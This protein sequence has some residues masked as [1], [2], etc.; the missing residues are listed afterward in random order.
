[1]MLCHLSHQVCLLCRHTAGI[2]RL[3]NLS[4]PQFE[5]FPTLLFSPCTLL[6]PR[7]SAVFYANI[8]LLQ[9]S[10]WPSRIEIFMALPVV[11]PFE[12][13]CMK[14]TLFVSNIELEILS[15]ALNDDALGNQFAR[16]VSIS[17]SVANSFWRWQLGDLV[18]TAA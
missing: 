2:L 14:Q 13:P 12:P 16:E 8:G 9:A 1:M 3:R 4:S 7:H 17:V 18:P 11:F 10:W 6:L 15:A 5:K